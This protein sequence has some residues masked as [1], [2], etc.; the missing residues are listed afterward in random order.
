MLNEPFLVIVSMP[1]LSFLLIHSLQYERVPILPPHIHPNKRYSH[2]K[3]HYNFFNVLYRNFLSHSLYLRVEEE[4][5]Y[6][7]FYI[8]SVFFNRFNRFFLAGNILINLKSFFP[9]QKHNKIEAFVII[10]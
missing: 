1:P 9:L 5:N 3:S 2:R 7:Q 4:K 6:L 8:Q 10:F